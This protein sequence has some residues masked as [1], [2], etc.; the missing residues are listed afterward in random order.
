MRKPSDDQMIRGAVWLTL[1]L[2]VLDR[3]IVL[4]GFA[5]THIGI[6]DALIMQVAV[7]YGNGIF[8]EPFLYGQN[9]NPMLEALLAAPFVRL[10]AVPWIVLPI[11]TSVLALLPFWSWSLWALRKGAIAASLVV[12]LVPLVLPAEWS[13]ITSMPRGWVHGLALMAFMP[14][15]L[16]ARHAWSRHLLLAFTSVAALLC[17]ANALPLTAA[18][19]LWLVLRDGRHVSLWISAALATAIGYGLHSAAQGWYAARTGSVVHPLGPDDLAF[20]PSLIADGF[21]NIGLHFQHLHTFGGMG[22]VAVAFL[23]VA[24]FF[25]LRQGEWRVAASMAAAVAILILALGIPKV[26]EGCASVFFPRS[27]MMLST[28][29]L[30]TGTLAWLLRGS[31][32]PRWFAIAGPV[33]ALITVLVRTHALEGTVKHELAQ[34]K[35]AW[36][37]EEPLRSVRDRCEA[38]HETAIT[39]GC[40]L[41]VPIRWPH[42][43]VDHR[44]HF[45]AHLTCYACP[46][47]IEGF[48]SAFGAGFDRRSWV[49]EAHDQAPQGRVLFVGGDVTAWQRAIAAGLIIEDVSGQGIPMHIAQCDSVAI[50]EFILRL[51]IDDD[52]GR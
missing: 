38:I 28:P 31:R 1:G 30:L 18:F 33:L 27:R 6:D 5:F 34:Q 52:L 19:A 49:R 15:L 9:Y 11:V 17:N 48:P 29:L 32:V 3:A 14:W 12:A 36:V 50:G 51:G 21:S 43:K 23:L 47:L 37:R 13:M 41:I 8:R 24:A 42:L 45:A 22:W 46:V 10:G 26:H 7:D 35:C 4:F 16:N 20:D 25:L 2:G 39:N 44:E 40:G